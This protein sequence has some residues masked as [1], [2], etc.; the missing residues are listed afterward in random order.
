MWV[1]ALLTGLLVGLVPTKIESNPDVPPYGAYGT[2]TPPK[3]ALSSPSGAFVLLPHSDM[4]FSLTSPA[5]NTLSHTNEPTSL[6]SPLGLSGVS[7]ATLSYTL[8]DTESSTGALGSC[9]SLQGACGEGLGNENNVSCD[10]CTTKTF[11]SEVSRLA[12]K[13][14]QS[15]TLARAIILCESRQYGSG[16]SHKNYDKQ[17]VWWS[18]DWGYWQINDY[19]NAAT[20]KR[21]GFDIYDKWE[22]LEF[23]FIMLKEQGTSPW[24]ASRGCWG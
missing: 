16:A 3:A 21:R 2:T 22:N 19:Y 1:A 8:R 14:H 20:A 4:V 11:D 6:F 15:E 23:G 12:A 13:Y 9:P 24:N 7:Y 18:T 10:N 5:L 17:G